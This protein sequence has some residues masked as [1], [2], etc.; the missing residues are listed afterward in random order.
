LSLSIQT[1]AWLVKIIFAIWA[2]GAGIKYAEMNEEWGK[3]RQGLE[4]RI[5]ILEL[6]CA[7]HGISVDYIMQ[8][9]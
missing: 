9:K 6:Q 4:H 7:A 1:T 2:I 8:E 3:E 5:R